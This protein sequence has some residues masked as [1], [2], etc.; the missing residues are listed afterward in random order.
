M[1]KTEEKL[2]CCLVLQST[3]EG[4]G[5]GAIRKILLKLNMG[6]VADNVMQLIDLLS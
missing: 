2:V 5:E 6:T 4:L 1:S 3:G